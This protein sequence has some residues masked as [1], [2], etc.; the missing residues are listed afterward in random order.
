MG[1]LGAPTCGLARSTLPVILSTSWK[2]N[3]ICE[4]QREELL[5]ISSLPHKS[6]INLQFY[7][8]WDGLPRS[9]VMHAI[10]EGFQVLKHSEKKSLKS[11]L[12]IIYFLFNLSH[13]SPC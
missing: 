3:R 5:V 8:L 6:V 13:I 7:F 1:T 12:L 9:S 10:T 2:P 4:G 11:H